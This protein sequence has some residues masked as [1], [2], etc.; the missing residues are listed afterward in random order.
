MHSD[1][2]SWDPESLTSLPRVPSDVWECG[3]FRFPAWVRDGEGGDYYR[4]PAIMWVSPAMGPGV[5][6][7]GREEEPTAAV[8]DSLQTAIM[9]HARF[10]SLPGALAVKDHDVAR[11]LREGVE[12]LG[13]RVDVVQETPRV[14]LAAR[15]HRPDADEGAEFPPGCLEARG[16]DVARVRAFADAAACFHRSRLWRYVNSGDLV[17]VRS[18]KPDPRLG[19]FSI[20]GRPGDRDVGIGFFSTMNQWKE[21]ARTNQD[22]NGLTFD[23]PTPAGA[24]TLAFS[25]QHEIPIPDSELWE[26]ESLPLAGP[27]AYP[28]P[29][30]DARSRIDRP[31]AKRLVFLECLLRTLAET[32]EDDIDSGEWE[33][34]VQTHDGERTCRLAIPHLK[35]PIIPDSGAPPTGPMR[36]FRSMERTMTSLSRH[37]TGQGPGPSSG[38]GRA[39]GQQF[40]GRRVPHLPG[41]TPLE[42][43]QDIVYQAFEIYGRRRVQMARRALEISPDCADAHVILAECSFDREDALRHWNLGVEAGRRSLGRRI[44]RNAGVTFWARLETRPFMRALHGR[45]LLLMEM[46]RYAEARRD[47]EE[48]LERNP[49]DNQGVRYSLIELLMRMGA[50]EDALRLVEEHEEEGSSVWLYARA[51]ALYRL[52]PA[53]PGAAAALSAAL[54]RHVG[55]A[56][57][58]L[59]QAEPPIPRE[60]GVI[61]MDSP[62]EDAWAAEVFQG[63][64]EQTPGAMDWLRDTVQEARRLRRGKR[65]AHRRGEDGRPGGGAG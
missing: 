42:L 38:H 11:A 55:V 27:A 23:I 43:A 44:F 26:R 2:L 7:L 10:M 46:E 29:A 40:V 16:V 18:E 17:R 20:T 33:R 22:R 12:P 35:A 58:I 14:D 3:L 56:R 41:S 65:R 64:W 61:R 59:G 45:S 57:F 28:F 30:R 13:I 39:A 50:D 47:M 63:P 5:T 6:L 60:E 62:E 49:G 21:M 48:M 1:R 53:S 9:G 19:W 31:D 15:L 54:A 37:I 52:D 25:A 32:T 36:D 51:L 34:T 8:L 4:P 24:W